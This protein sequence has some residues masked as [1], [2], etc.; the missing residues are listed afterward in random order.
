MDDEFRELYGALGGLFRALVGILIA[1]FAV[2]LFAYLLPGML[3]AAR[4]PEFESFSES[5]SEFAKFR[6]CHGRSAM[7]NRWVNSRN[8]RNLSLRHIPSRGPQGQALEV[9]QDWR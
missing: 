4:G 2:I 8:I 7:G 5:M 9:H 1:F 6:L 3:K